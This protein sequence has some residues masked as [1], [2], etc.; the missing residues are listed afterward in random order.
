MVCKHIVLQW[1]R[2]GYG[3]S[4]RLVLRLCLSRDTALPII[5]I[6][7]RKEVRHEN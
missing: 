7:R 6:L 3:F 1:L 2:L 4:R 5:Q